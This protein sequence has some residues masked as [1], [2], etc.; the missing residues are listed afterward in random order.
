MNSLVLVEMAAPGSSTSF[1]LVLLG[2]VVGVFIAVIGMEGVQFLFISGNIFLLRFVF[3]LLT[4][5]HHG[6][7]NSICHYVRLKFT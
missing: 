7:G 5:S 4:D 2:F 6:V 3:Y 1:K